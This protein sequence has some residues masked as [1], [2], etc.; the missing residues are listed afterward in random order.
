MR[1]SISCRLG[2]RLVCLCLLATSALAADAP[3]VNSLASELPSVVGVDGAATVEGDDTLLDIAVRNDVGFD[4]LIRLNPDMDV[5]MPP[6]GAQVSLPVRMIPPHAPHTGLVINIPEMRL[7]DYTQGDIPTVLPIA[8]GDPATP[9]PIGE[10]RVLWK[11]Q[12]PV[13]RVPESIRLRDP[14]LPREVPPG[15]DNPLG[16]HWLALGDGY[17]IHGTNNLWS[18]GR[19][20][21][22]G[23]I[24]LQNRTVKELYARVKVRTPVHL[25]YQT[26]KLGREGQVVYLEA[27]RDLYSLAGDPVPSLLAHLL[28]LGVLDRVDRERL[29]SVVSEARGVPVR[30]TEVQEETPIAVGAREELGLEE[31]AP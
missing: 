10:R 17:G 5:W 11:T 25:V 18:I 1:E 13:W 26:V 4:A 9:T 19:I 27:H 22:H 8:I 23:C 24:R 14:L 30:I 3:K 2:P 12:D 29:A 31:P 21:T 7:Y 20:A 15:E 28:M 6:E 16:S